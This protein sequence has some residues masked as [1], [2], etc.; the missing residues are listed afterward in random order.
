MLNEKVDLEVYGR[1]FTVEFEGITPI[2][3]PALAKD[4]TQRMEKIAQETAI[5]DTSKLA[6]LA[7][8]EVL[9]ENSRLKAEKDLHKAAEE[10]SLDQMTISLQNTLDSIAEKK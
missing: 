1:R 6:I 3:L 9:V 7:A 2:E 8:L 5:V 10:R 4:L